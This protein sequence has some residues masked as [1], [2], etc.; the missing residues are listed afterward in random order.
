MD[1][2]HPK[3]G[4]LI[5]RLNTASAGKALP[6][7]T[8]PTPLS[9]IKQFVFTGAKRGCFALSKFDSD[10][11]RRLAVLLDREVSVQKWMKPGP[12][13]FRIEDENGEPYHP[14]FAV[15][16]ET[17]KLI[18]ELKRRSEMQ[19]ADVLRKARS[20]TLWCHVATEH[21]ARPAGGKPWRYALIPDD[22][23]QLSATLA[24]LLSAYTVLPDI[25]LLGRYS[26]TEAA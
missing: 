19:D 9:A 16:T 24:G 17:E 5:P 15:E 12:G 3:N 2:D 22:A 1:A 26:L 7:T 20:A 8:A 23:I 4:V 25:E 6:L 13:Q 21:H 11:E 18:L 14:D 10:P